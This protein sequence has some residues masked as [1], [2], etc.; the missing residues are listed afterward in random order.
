[1][2][3]RQKNFRPAPSIAGFSMIDVLV[4]IVV[5]ATAL[6]ALAALQGAL[7]RNA[8]DARSRSQIA[9]YTE[10]L[11]DQLRAAGFGNIASATINPVC[12]GTPTKQ[13]VEACAAQT[14]AGVTNLTTTITSLPYYSSAPTTGVFTQTGTAPSTIF[15]TYNQVKVTTTWT[16]ASGQA[17]TFA[18]DTIVSPVQVDPNNRSLD[19]TQLVGSVGS[20]PIVR[21]YNPGLTPGVIPI[22]MGTTGNSTAATNPQPEILGKNNNQF[23]G[24]VS[25]NV[26]TFGADDGTANHETQITQNIATRVIRCSCKYGAQVTTG[27]FAQPYRPTYWD[28]SQVKYVSPSKAS[29]PVSTTGQDST[30]TQDTNCDVCCRDRNDSASD[31]IRYNPWDTSDN[32]HYRYVNSTDTSPTV[33]SPGDTADAFVNACRVIIVD[34]V[35]NV[36]TDMQ[37]YFFGFVGTDTAAVQKV[38]SGS[39][40]TNTASS[41]LPTS[42]F[43]DDYQAFVK[44][45][46]LETGGG[47]TLT[48]GAAGFTT[49]TVLTS[50]NYPLNAP[51]STASTNAAGDLYATNGLAA[52]GVGL[53]ANIP[54]TYVDPGKNKTAACIPTGTQDCRYLH[55]RGLYVDHLEAVT[56]AAINSAISTCASNALLEN[57]VLPLMPFTT[58]NIT[59]LA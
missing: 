5:L 7:T 9:A 19:S 41:P 39:S 1:M 58:I 15:G 14:A 32:S 16:D 46:L 27:V 45:Y 33:V 10:G 34:G 57:C 28:A 25:F 40:S 31:S 59:Q 54:I 49:S 35:F 52:N 20:K 48:A 3:I 56:L 30:A 55:A 24:G 6:L 11:V 18:V 44:A 13:Q 50:S 26:L 38:P 2:I 17:R 4:A 23:I 51:S 37:N 47:N 21:Q 12:T 22:A 42:T 53:P 29:S 8:A 36:A 43:T